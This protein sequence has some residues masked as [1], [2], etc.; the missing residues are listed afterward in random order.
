[1]PLR[2]GPHRSRLTARVN[3]T[4][5]GYREL[6]RRLEEL[7]QVDREGQPYSTR[8]DAAHRAWRGGGTS[9][10]GL[11]LAANLGVGC[12]Q[13]VAQPLS[14][15]EWATQACPPLRDEGAALLVS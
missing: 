6:V 1:L 14:W 7:C 5:H 3:P 12:G 9:R 2:A 4:L 11:T 10:G 8:G 15:C 13:P